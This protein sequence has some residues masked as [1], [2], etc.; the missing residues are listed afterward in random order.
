MEWRGTP[1][2][3]K[4]MVV[5]KRRRRRG[6]SGPSD[7]VV[8]RTVFSPLLSIGLLRFCALCFGF[9]SNEPIVFILKFQA[10]L[11]EQKSNNVLFCKCKFLALVVNQTRSRFDFVN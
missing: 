4:W 8:G 2:C 6:L 10:M 11:K 9:D 1:S 3:A 5:V 7:G